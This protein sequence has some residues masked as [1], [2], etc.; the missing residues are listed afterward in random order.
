MRTISSSLRWQEFL[1]FGLVFILLSGCTRVDWVPDEE[2][3]DPFVKPQFSIAGSVC[4]SPS[5][6]LSY[7]LRVLFVVDGSESME[8]SDPP[9]PETDERGRQR[10]V[11]Q[12]WETLL[13]ESQGDEE[14]RIGIMRFSAQ[15][16][17]LTEVDTDE[18]GAI[19]SVFTQNPDQLRAATDKLSFTDRTTNYLTALD[20]IYFALRQEALRGIDQDQEALGRSRYVVIFLSDGLPSDGANNAQGGLSEQVQLKL[21][22]ILK[23]KTLFGIGEI[24]FHTVFVSNEQG[25]AL[26]QPA[27]ELLGRMADVG[28]GSYRSVSRGEEI[29][30][31]HIE[32]SRIQRLYSLKALVPVMMNAV[33]NADQHPQSFVEEWDQ[34]RFLDADQDGRLSCGEPMSDSDQ[35]GLGDLFEMRLGTDPTQADSDGD[36]LSDRVE[37]NLRRSGLSPLDGQDAQC[38]VPEVANESCD[39]QDQDG[40][41]DLLPPIKDSD[42]DGLND[43]EELFFGSLSNAVD[44]D[45]DGLPDLLEFRFGTSPVQKDETGDLDWDGTDNFVEVLNGFDPLCDDAAIRSR[46][47]YARELEEIGIGSQEEQSLEMENFDNQQS[48]YTFS[49]RG[50]PRTKM[51]N[52]EDNRVLLFAGEGAFDEKSNVSRWRIACVSAPL[53]VEL[54]S[55]NVEESHLR[56]KGPIFTLQHED[57]IAPAQFDPEQHCRQTI[58]ENR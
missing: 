13:E 43:C 58:K 22:E 28:Q 37:W 32:L 47:G 18:D 23:L 20:Q 31:V 11:R 45:D 38:Q 26:D 12:T 21:S 42:G 49:V 9:D 1:K 48:C 14:S 17:F 34:G 19:D 46:V 27:Q 39:D 29:N 51:M 54:E 3:L 57:F 8:V 56:N 36:G 10:A 50:L 6:E 53:D 30:F 5:K 24:R 41:C 40:Y 16:E 52:Q 55:V 15:A 7:P 25:L 4:T 44:S 35:D 2:I 33:Q